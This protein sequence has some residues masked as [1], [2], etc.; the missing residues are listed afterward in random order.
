MSRW[1]IFWAG[2]AP[3]LSIL[4]SFINLTL[5]AHAA[6]Q[7]LHVLVIQ[8]SLEADHENSGEVNYG[9]E[10][11]SEQQ[12]TEDDEHIVGHRFRWSGT[13][14]HPARVMR[15]ASPVSQPAKAASFGW[16]R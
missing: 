8:P 16:A 7:P 1:F 3:F 12:Q 10:S 6:L 4:F 9:P 14:A 2:T 13:S 11:L 15:W 5:Y